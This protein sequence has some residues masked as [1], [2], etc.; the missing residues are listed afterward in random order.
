MFKITP[1]GKETLLHDFAGGDDGA[2]PFSNVV[3]DKDGNLYGTTVDGGNG[4]QQGAD[5]ENDC[6]TVYKMSRGG[7]IA[8]LHAFTGLDDGG[9]PFGGITID[10]QG[11]TYG[12]TQKAGAGHN[13][14]LFKVT[15]EGAYSVV[16]AFA[17]G[18][19]DG[20]R[21]IGNLTLDDA[22]NIYGR[23]L[24]GL[25]NLFKVTPEGAGCIREL[26]RRRRRRQQGDP[27]MQRRLR[28]RLSAHRGG[29]VQRPVQ[30]RGA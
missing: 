23:A 3:M 25:G 12:T 24:G 7:N 20:A 10:A 28:H 15:P 6:G 21:P 11:N 14:V 5:C 29:Q 2:E 13:G 1:K 19:D 27:Q 18:S 17:G 22:G 8:I 9:E 30:L 26:L 4:R 16:H